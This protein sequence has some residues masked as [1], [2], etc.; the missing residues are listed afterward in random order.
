MT[1][2]HPK[3]D[4]TQGLFGVRPV[5]RRTQRAVVGSWGGPFTNTGKRFCV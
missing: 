4:P 1:P 3:S 5:L 2:K